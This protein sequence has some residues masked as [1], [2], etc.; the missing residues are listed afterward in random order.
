VTD[1]PD[2]VQEPVIFPHELGQ[3]ADGE[4]VCTYRGQNW[5]GRGVPYF[6]RWRS[7]AGRNRTLTRAE[8]VGLPY[9]SGDRTRSLP[10]PA[11]PA[12]TAPAAL[13]AD[14]SI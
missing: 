14:Q 12:G 7:F 10:L 5:R 9:S 2:L 13:G 3:L 8:R 4:M 11:P 1:S 6:E